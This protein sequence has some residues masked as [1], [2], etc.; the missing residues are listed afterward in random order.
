MGWGQGWGTEEGQD[1]RKHVE[2]SKEE[3]QGREKNPL[4]VDVLTQ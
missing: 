4:L 1:G 2:G 3:A